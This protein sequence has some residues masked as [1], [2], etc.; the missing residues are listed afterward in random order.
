[1]DLELTEEVKHYIREL[2]GL[3]EKEQIAQYIRRQKELEHRLMMP[4]SKLLKN[5]ICEIRPGPHRFLYFYFNSKMIVVHAFRKK[6]QRTPEREIQ[7]A[8]R[9]RKQWLG[10]I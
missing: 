9:R 5:G 3:V 10:G 8:F 2:S 6:S 1:M 7:T 4:V